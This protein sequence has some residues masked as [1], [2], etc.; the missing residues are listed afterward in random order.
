MP[1]PKETITH[2]V[3]QG[4]NKSDKSIPATHRN[5]GYGSNQRTRKRQEARGDRAAGFLCSREIRKPGSY[6]HSIVAGGFELIS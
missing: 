3:P 5:G 4:K 2:Q 1:S 6:S